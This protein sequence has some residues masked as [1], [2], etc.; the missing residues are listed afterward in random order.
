[1][2]RTYIP[3]SLRERVRAQA[4]GRCGYC[5]S[6]ELISGQPLTIEH[7]VPQARGGLTVENNLWLSCAQCNDHK[8]KRITAVDPQTRQRVPLF[9]PRHQSWL[10]HF[11]WVDGG[12]LIEG[13]TPT[14]RATV[15]ALQLN[16]Q[17]LV[18]ARR[19]WVAVGLHPPDD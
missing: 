8:G 5:L 17:V 19:I 1:V 9:D 6:R 16:R 7:I 3:R 15:V 12:T 11:V 13:R 14:G 18:D 10:E 4:R 2:T